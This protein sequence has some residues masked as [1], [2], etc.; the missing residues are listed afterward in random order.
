MNPSVSQ[1]TPNKLFLLFVPFLLL[2]AACDEH[3]TPRPKGY[4]RIS[5]PEKHYE[6][7]ETRCPLTTEVPVYSK[8]EVLQTGNDSCWFNVYIPQHNARLHCT[9]LEVNRDLNA[10]IEDAYQFAFQHEMKADAIRRTSYQEDSS[11][12]FAMVYDLEGDVASPIQFY[13][14]DSTQHFLRGSLYFEHIPNADS[15]NP[16]VNFLREDIIHL[17]THIQWQ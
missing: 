8:I 5:F 2:L 3:Y 7:Y 14:T 16:V 17:L 6:A 1:L 15:L 12:V 10:M 9:Y 11:R 4:F 13:A